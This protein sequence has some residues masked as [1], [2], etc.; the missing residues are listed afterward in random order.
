M[1]PEAPEAEHNNDKR[2]PGVLLRPVDK[3]VSNEA[4]H[5]AEHGDDDDASSERERARFDC[6][7]G[8]STN[9]YTG[10]GEAKSVE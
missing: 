9:D 7:Q 3:V 1:C 4:R 6:S 8:L 10:H 5:K 2:Y